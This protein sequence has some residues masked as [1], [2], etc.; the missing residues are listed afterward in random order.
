[1]KTWLILLLAVSV[2]CLAFFL[3]CNG[4]KSS[5]SSTATEFG[6]CCINAACSVKTYGDCNNADGAWQGPKTACSPNPCVGDDDDDASPDDDDDSVWVPCACCE[7]NVGGLDTA[8]SSITQ[9]TC[10]A[11]WHSYRFCSSWPCNFATGACCPKSGACEDYVAATD[12]TAAGYRF[13]ENA[14]CNGG[15]TCTLNDDDGT[16]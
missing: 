11:A 15:T 13:F 1:M 4:S 14:P 16:P 6:A 2:G 12:C 3:A 8:S 5:S 7:V 9:S 10:P